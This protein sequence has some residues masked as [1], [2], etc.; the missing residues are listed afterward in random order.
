M[1]AFLEHS[2]VVPASPQLIEGIKTKASRNPQGK[3]EKLIPATSHLRQE[4]AEESVRLDRAVRLLPE[5]GLQR[6][7]Q[8]GWP[9]H[10]S[11]RR[12]S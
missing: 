4:I 7:G 1:H 10:P 2:W 11:P 9:K 12:T 5:A 8:S 6:L 3:D